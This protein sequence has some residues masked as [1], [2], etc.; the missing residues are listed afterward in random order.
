MSNELVVRAWEQTEVEVEVGS[1]VDLVLSRPVAIPPR[2]GCEW[3]AAPQIAGASVRFAG[4]R[5]ELPPADAD[6]GVAT[7]HYG[8]EAVGPGLSRVLLTAVPASAEAVCPPV[9]LELRV[10]PGGSSR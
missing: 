1:A 3:P 8:F 7:L 2:L 10:R 4:R 5:I 9:R 6:G